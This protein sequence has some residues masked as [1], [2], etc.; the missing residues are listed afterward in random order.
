MINRTQFSSPRYSGF[1]GATQVT[2]SSEMK[3]SSPCAWMAR[4]RVK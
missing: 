1:P 2:R 4:E 3:Y